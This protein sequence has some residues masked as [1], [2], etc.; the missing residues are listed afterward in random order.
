MPWFRWERDHAMRWCPALYDEKPVNPP[1]ER[2]DRYTALTHV[3]PQTTLE[4]A[5]ILHPAPRA[6]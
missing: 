2:A 4:D 3:D 1:R 6:E 5:V